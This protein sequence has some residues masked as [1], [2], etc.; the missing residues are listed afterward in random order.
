VYSTMF[1]IK[2]KDP[3]TVEMQVR[4]QELTMKLDTGVSTTV[5]GENVFCEL[6]KTGELEL[7]RSTKKLRTYMADVGID[8][9]RPHIQ[10]TLLR[11]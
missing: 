10:A 11:G 5:I 6:N 9:F 1:H 7:C 3:I 8:P 4:G 2:S